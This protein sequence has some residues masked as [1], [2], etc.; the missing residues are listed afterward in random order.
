MNFQY[1]QRSIRGSGCVDDEDF[2]YNLKGCEC[3]NQCSSLNGCKCL[4]YGTVR[5]SYSFNLC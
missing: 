5:M 2:E 1:E 3:N 4:A